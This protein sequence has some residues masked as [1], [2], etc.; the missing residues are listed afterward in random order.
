MIVPS[1]ALAN[2]LK[3]AA[4]VAVAPTAAMNCR[5]FKPPDLGWLPWSFSFAIIP[6]PEGLESEKV[7]H[8]AFSTNRRPKLCHFCFRQG[9]L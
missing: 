6:L 4:E 9:K 7:Q 5:R 3:N 1:S 2:W 8:I